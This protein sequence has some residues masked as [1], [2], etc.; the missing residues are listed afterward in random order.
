MLHSLCCSCF[1]CCEHDCICKSLMFKYKREFKLSVKEKFVENCWLLRDIVKFQKFLSNLE[2]AWG[3]Y[4]WLHHSYTPGIYF[5]ATS[6]D[7]TQSM[8][9]I[10]FKSISFLY[11]S[12]TYFWYLL[13]FLFCFI[14]FHFLVAVSTTG[15]HCCNHNHP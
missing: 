14:C 5:F 12:I 9:G 13:A 8:V 3:K 2:C 15:I 4:L 6:R 10:W 11:D 1:K 7:N